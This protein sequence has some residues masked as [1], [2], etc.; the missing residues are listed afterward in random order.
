[1]DSH[2]FGRLIDG[3]LKEDES[4]AQGISSWSLLRRTICIKS[5]VA[6]VGAGEPGVFERYR[7]KALVI[8]LHN[9]QV[10]KKI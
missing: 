8:T 3:C 6:S 7:K 9:L 5:F 4:M 1:M 10:K 2:V